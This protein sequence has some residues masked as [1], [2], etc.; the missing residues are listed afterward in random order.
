MAEYDDP[1]R[2]YPSL[3]AEI[4]IGGVGILVES[5][6]GGYT[7]TLAVA[8]IIKGEK[9]ETQ[10]TQPGIVYWSVELREVPR[11]A[12]TDQEPQLVRIWTGWDDPARQR[13]PLLG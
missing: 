4:A 9:I 1:V 2:R 13:K 12:M 7:L 6:F 11:V 10:P 3:V 5:R 8:P